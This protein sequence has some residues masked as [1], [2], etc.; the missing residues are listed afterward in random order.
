MRGTGERCSRQGSSDLFHVVYSKENKGEQNYL[1]Q[2]S[3]WFNN[4]F[5]LFTYESGVSVHC[6]FTLL[7][8]EMLKKGSH[9]KQIETVYKLSTAVVSL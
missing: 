2:S 8:R 7:E 3:D 5:N 4:S 6:S 1:I 9:D